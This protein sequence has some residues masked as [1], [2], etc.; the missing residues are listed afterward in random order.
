ML[1]HHPHLSKERASQ[2]S[3]LKGGIEEPESR[4]LAQAGSGMLYSET[5]RPQAMRGRQD[6]RGSSARGDK[7]RAG[8]KPRVISAAHY[9]PCKVCEC[10][11]QS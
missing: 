11:A 10:Q 4:K 8:D 2:L 7:Q 5:G 9:S 3:V 6:P 1:Y